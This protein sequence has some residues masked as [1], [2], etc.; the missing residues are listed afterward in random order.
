MSQNINRYSYADFTGKPYIYYHGI[1]YAKNT[2]PP[3][4]NQED[5]RTIIRTNQQCAPRRNMQ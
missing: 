3:M 4:T 5:N 2:N 1:P